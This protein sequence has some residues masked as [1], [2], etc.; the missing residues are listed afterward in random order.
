MIIKHGECAA[1]CVAVSDES[2]EAIKKDKSLLLKQDF[3]IELLKE[4]GD[5]LHIVRLDG[6]ISPTVIMRYVKELRKE[7]KTVSWYNRDMS[8]LIRR[9]IWPRQSQL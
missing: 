4:D 8:K 5:N 6:N 1:Y 2:L 9:R 7:F 3:L